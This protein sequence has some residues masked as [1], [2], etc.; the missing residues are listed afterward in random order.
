MNTTKK[1][2][3][4]ALIATVALGALISFKYPFFNKNTPKTHNLGATQSFF[5]EKIAQEEKELINRLKA[6]LG[7]DLSL[8]TPS[9]DHWLGSPT[10]AQ[11]TED[12]YQLVFDVAQKYNFNADKL[13]IVLQHSDQG[14]PA[15]TNS[16]G[17]L[18]IEMNIFPTLPVSVQRF[19]IAHELH[20]ILHNDFEETRALNKT[21]NQ[22]HV[23]GK[24]QAL[25]DEY[26]RFQEKRADVAAA[27]RGA[28][29]A[30][31]YLDFAHEGIKRCAQDPG[32][33]HP[34]YKERAAL[35][36]TIIDHMHG[37]QTV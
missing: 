36:Q 32:I 25:L 5:K 18:L 19:I 6:E 14:S 37:L 10:K 3:G 26:G 15:S 13:S 23:S 1:Y 35:A 31:G 7:V 22:K 20:H 29:W 16:A 4:I 34:T 11:G 28:E 12:I 17:Q 2:Y 30:Q 8:T 9:Q 33:S 24:A 27:L 21:L